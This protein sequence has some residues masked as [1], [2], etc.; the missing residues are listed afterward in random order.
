MRHGVTW[1][2]ALGLLAAL[3]APAAAQEKPATSG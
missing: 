1:G 2:M 3:A